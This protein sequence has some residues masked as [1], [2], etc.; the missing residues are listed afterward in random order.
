VDQPGGQE[1]LSYVKDNWLGKEVTVTVKGES[2]GRTVA[3]IATNEEKPKSMGL[4]LVAKGL[5][6]VDERYSRNAA[7]LDAQ[8]KAQEQKL[9]IWKSG[10]Q[11]EAPWDF[12]KRAR[13]RG[14]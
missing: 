9:G 13:T 12:R 6:M 4:D 3:T 5:A 14:K 10:T 1:A 7:L 11:V 2:Y 8:K